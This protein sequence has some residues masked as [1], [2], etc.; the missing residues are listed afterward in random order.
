MTTYLPFGCCPLCR[1]QFKDDDRVIEHQV[2]MGQPYRVL[3][4]HCYLQVLDVEVQRATY[5]EYFI[6]NANPVDP[7]LWPVGT[8]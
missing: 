6:Q 7:V 3:H 4:V 1:E 2:L 5:W 8:G